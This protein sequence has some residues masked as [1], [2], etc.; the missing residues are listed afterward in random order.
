[1]TLSHNAYGPT[2]P[3]S[4]LTIL[5][6]LK[7]VHK[8]SMH[9]FTISAGI[10]SSKHNSVYQTT[11]VL[12]HQLLK[13]L[14]PKMILVHHWVAQMSSRVTWRQVNTYDF[15]PYSYKFILK[16]FR[17]QG[18]SKCCQNRHDLKTMPI[19]H[20]QSFI[21]TQITQESWQSMSQMQWFTINVELWPKKLTSRHSFLYKSQT[22]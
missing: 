4:S 14:Q 2:K 16:Q 11:R 17:L 19:Y 8:I 6:V 5:A 12:T 18:H 3:W 7:S 13:H 21:H 22:Q 1:M 15:H 20:L 9:L 10:S